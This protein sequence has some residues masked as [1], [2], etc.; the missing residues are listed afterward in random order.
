MFG[1]GGMQQEQCDLFAPALQH[2]H[3]VTLTE[4]TARQHIIPVLIQHV[5]VVNLRCSRLDTDVLWGNRH[6]CGTMLVLTGVAVGVVERGK[7][8]GAGG[9][10]MQGRLACRTGE[11]G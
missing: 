5:F 2:T 6:G 4:H 8:W 7:R 3:L 1:W 10:G 11:A 9:M